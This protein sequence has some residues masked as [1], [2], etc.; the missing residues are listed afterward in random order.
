MSLVAADAPASGPAGPTSAP[1]LP[2]I[3]LAAHP[4][5]G[6][7]TMAAAT[8]SA[9]GDGLIHADDGSDVDDDDDDDS[10]DDEAGGKATD[11]HSGSTAKRAGR[12]SALPRGVS[13]IGR[14]GPG[15]PNR[16]GVRLRFARIQVRVGSRFCSVEAA[17]KV[18]HAF[19][20]VVAF[21]PNDLNARV[22]TDKLG[23]YEA[24]EV[25]C[26]AKYKS[27]REKVSIA[28]L[29]RQWLQTWMTRGQQKRKRKLPDIMMTATAPTQAAD[30]HGGGNSSNGLSS[31]GSNSN[32]IG[33]G[34]GPHG[35]SG[36]YTWGGGG[37]GGGAG[38]ALLGAP[39]HP[40]QQQA[41]MGGG[42]GGIGPG[43][44]PAA[45]GAMYTD[46]PPVRCALD[47]GPRESVRPPASLSSAS[48]L[49]RLQFFICFAVGEVCSGGL[50]LP[51]PPP[52]PPTHPF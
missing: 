15:K 40:Q 11:G 41:F 36:H 29:I 10:G 39:L 1:E 43:M 27:S 19:R 8:T 20:D 5:V 21:A 34:L 46:S 12:R 50:P 32:I 49:P 38:A 52:T 23:K 3:A 18:A 26:F 17:D 25:E 24:P 16:Y 44:I 4:V 13:V 31:G 51:P 6:G 28:T 22:D 2:K 7:G 45:Y 33:L 30:I 42:G 9:S 48:W 37:G 14:P 47:P 35:G